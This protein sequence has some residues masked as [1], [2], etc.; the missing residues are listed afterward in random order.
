[1]T[2]RYVRSI[3]QV[4]GMYPALATIYIYMF[5]HYIVD[6]HSNVDPRVLDF[7]HLGNHQHEPDR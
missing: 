3:K 5:R 7:S 6:W 2:V 1:M 4:Q